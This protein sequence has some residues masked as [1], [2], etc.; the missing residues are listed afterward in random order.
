MPY[1]HCGAQFFQSGIQFGKTV[2]TNALH[3]SAIEGNAVGLWRGGGGDREWQQRGLKGLKNWCKK[4]EK[5]QTES[6]DN[7]DGHLS[8]ATGEQP[9]PADDRPLD[10]R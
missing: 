1:L 10:K 8:D 2:A 7:G 9:T 4:K 6:L 5:I 3:R